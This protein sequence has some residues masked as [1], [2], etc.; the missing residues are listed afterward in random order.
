MADFKIP[1]VLEEMIP[2]GLL[3]HNHLHKQA[4]R[5]NSNPDK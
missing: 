1:L 3:I 5:Q 2:D 4:D